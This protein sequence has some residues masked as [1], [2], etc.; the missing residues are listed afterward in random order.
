MK[1]V[2]LNLAAVLLASAVGAAELKSG[3]QPG[4]LVGVCL[5][6][7]ADMIA[8]V[9]AVTESPVLQ[10][11]G[12]LDVNEVREALQF[13]GALAEVAATVTLVVAAMGPAA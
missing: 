6:R 1:V 3:L 8:A 2:M 11:S 12:T 10:A 13:L 7:S 9:L 4:D 5:K